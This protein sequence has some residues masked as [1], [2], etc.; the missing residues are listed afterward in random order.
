[1]A[2]PA[3]QQR[4]DA[5]LATSM[6]D[7]IKAAPSLTSLELTDTGL[8]K[9]APAALVKHRPGLNAL[10]L[11]NFGQQLQ[12]C[13]PDICR[14]T[15][16]TSLTHWQHGTLATELLGLGNLQRLNLPFTAIHTTNELD[17]LLAAT[18]ITALTVSTALPHRLVSISKKCTMGTC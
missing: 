15:G 7:L 14:L 9:Y 5:A 8:E 18:Q 2:H 6:Q 13:V 10:Q 17:V 3:E 11:Q 16:L 1:M 12:Q 4:A